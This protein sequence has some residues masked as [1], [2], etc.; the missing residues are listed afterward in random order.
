MSSTN[1]KGS[2]ATVSGTP[3]SL[4][5]LKSIEKP[6]KSRTLQK[7]TGHQSRYVWYQNWCPV[8]VPVVGLEPTRSRPRRILNPLRLPFHHTGIQLDYY[9]LFC[10]QMQEKFAPLKQGWCRPSNPTKYPPGPGKTGSRGYLC[11]SLRHA[12]LAYSKPISQFSVRPGR[13]RV[14]NTK[15]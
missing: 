9:T 3:R 13:M 7:E 4:I 15:N 11:I 10:G 6:C 8:M 2:A 14:R 5:S 1:E 12:H